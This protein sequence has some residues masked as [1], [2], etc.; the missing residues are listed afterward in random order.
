[1]SL[2]EVG[3]LFME[4]LLMASDSFMALFILSDPKFL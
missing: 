1:M 2:I 3:K 4:I